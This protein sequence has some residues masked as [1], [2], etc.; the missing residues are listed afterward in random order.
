VPS[1]TLMSSSR[2]IL[3]EQSFQKLLAAAYILQQ[4]RDQLRARQASDDARRLAEIADTQR[5][6]H[7]QKLTLQDTLQLVAERAAKITQGVGTA[8]YLVQDGELKCCA[9]SGR[10]LPHLGESTRI[11]ESAASACLQS[12]EPFRCADV[13]AQI[14]PPLRTPPASSLFA[15]P[16]HRGGRVD[17]MLEVLFGSANGFQERDIQSGMLL[18]GMVEEAFVR[19]AEEKMKQ[20]LAAERATMLAALERL[21]PQLEKLSQPQPQTEAVAAPPPAT[22][23]PESRPSGMAGLGAFLLNMQEQQVKRPV[24]EQG[25]AVHLARAAQDEVEELQPAPPNLAL[26]SVRPASPAPPDMLSEEEIALLQQPGTETAEEQDHQYHV[27]EDLPSFPQQTTEPEADQVLWPQQQVPANRWIGLW[28]AH[29]ADV[30]L[31]FASVV[32]LSVVLWAVWPR[33]AA[34]SPASPTSDLTPLERMLVAIGL[35]EPPPAPTYQGN[36]NAKVWVD[37]QTA[38]YYCSGSDLYGKTPKGK[39]TTQQ[40]ALRDQFEPAYR[41]PCR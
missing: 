22:K 31:V 3:D 36:P 25:P 37:L 41:R 11:E 16:V 40:D 30:F 2:V 12:E 19:D 27:L 15:I 32:L 1:S 33:T 10:S 28:R 14:A 13:R 18:A 20:E 24:P 34:S 35:A 38:I 29:W 21:K 26:A 5:V 9:A 23:E 39:Y 17:G 8:I 6:I 7:T 4:Q